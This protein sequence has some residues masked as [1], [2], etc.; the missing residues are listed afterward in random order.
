MK[1]ARLIE[2]NACKHVFGV[3]DDYAITKRA[4]SVVKHWIEKM[5]KDMVLPRKQE[6]NVGV[7]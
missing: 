2:H 1:R 6:D 4:S 7:R 3:S 5:R